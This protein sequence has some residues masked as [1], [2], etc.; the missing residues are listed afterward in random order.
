MSFDKNA[1]L[2]E[3][4]ELVSQGVLFTIV[5][6]LLPHLAGYGAARSKDDADW[7]Q[8]RLLSREA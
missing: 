4:P 3:R 1:E 7:P 2:V 5:T 8:V 6:N